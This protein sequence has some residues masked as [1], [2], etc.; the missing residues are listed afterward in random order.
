MSMTMEI[1]WS[2]WCSLLQGL[3]KEASF[4]GKLVNIIS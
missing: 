4:N 1:D 3:E 2:L